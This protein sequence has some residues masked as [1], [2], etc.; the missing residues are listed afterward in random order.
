MQTKEPRAGPWSVELLLVEELVEV[1]SGP[2]VLEVSMPELVVLVA[3]VPVVVPS[4]LVLLVSV[5]A[6][7]Q[8]AIRD[9]RPTEG[10]W[11]SLTMRTFTAPLA[12]PIWLGSEPLYEPFPIWMPS[13][14]ASNSPTRVKLKGPPA[15]GFQTIFCWTLFGSGFISCTQLVPVHRTGAWASTLAGNGSGFD[16]PQPPR[17]TT[18]AMTGARSQRVDLARIGEGCR[19]MVMRFLELAK[20]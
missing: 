2:G 4:V 20:H 11:L 9:C 10:F 8:E 19:F 6:G 3:V 12:R 5:G 17:L 16:E 15:Q 1:V 7:S 13:R 14:P 18:P